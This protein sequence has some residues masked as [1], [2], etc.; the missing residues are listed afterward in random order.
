MCSH[1]RVHTHTH[2]HTMH[3]HTHTITNV[4]N[5]NTSCIAAKCTCVQNCTVHTHL[6]KQEWELVCTKTNTL[7]TR[8]R[9]CLYKNKHF[10]NKSESLYVQKQTLCKQEWELVCTKTNTLVSNVN[11]KSHMFKQRRI[12]GHQSN[13]RCYKMKEWPPSP[14]RTHQKRQLITHSHIGEDKNSVSHISES[15]SDLKEYLQNLRQNF[16][17]TGL[18]VKWILPATVIYNTILKRN[19]TENVSLKHRKCSN[20]FICMLHSAVLLILFYQY[21]INDWKSIYGA[22]KLP[23]KTLHAH[24]A[25]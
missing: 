20:I 13:H 24:T 25:S 9:A 14:K 3:A 11:I 6:W 17:P 23:H 10:A 18:H 2:T 8:V 16:S 15:T 22:K 21:W 12:H 7:Q 4:L 19:Q 5:S 1:A